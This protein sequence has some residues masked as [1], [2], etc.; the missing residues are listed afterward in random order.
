MRHGSLLTVIETSVSEHDMTSSWLE[1]T[2]ENYLSKDDV[3]KSQFFTTILVTTDVNFKTKTIATK[4]GVLGVFPLRLGD[5]V[6]CATGPYI[7]HY[8]AL[9]E[10]RRLYDDVQKAFLITLRPAL[11][12]RRG[13]C[14]SMRPRSILLTR[15]RFSK[16]DDGGH[17]CDCSSVAVRS[18]LA[19]SNS[20]QAMRK[21]RAAIKD[22]FDIAGVKISLCSKEYLSLYPPATP[23]ATAIAGLVERGIQVLG[24]TKLSSLLS[25][26][27]PSESVD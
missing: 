5:G 11:N 10:V 15:A 6:Q 14:A 24:K 9:W 25:R 18:R 1:E 16:L 17:G 20:P 26:E 22:A 3:I 19:S 8:D 21:Y 12:G 13:C 4:W 2:L 27:E 23:T 7:V